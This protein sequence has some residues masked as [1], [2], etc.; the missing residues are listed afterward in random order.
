MNNFRE[1]RR[2]SWWSILST[3]LFVAFAALAS[4][5]IG[6]AVASADP[7][8]SPLSIH[9][10]NPPE[11]R[12]SLSIDQENYECKGQV[13]PG[14]VSILECGEQRQA[15]AEFK[16]FN[17]NK[18]GVLAVYQ[19]GKQSGAL[20]LMERQGQT[21]AVLGF[22]PVTIPGFGSLKVFETYIINPMKSDLSEDE[23][24]QTLPSFIRSLGANVNISTLRDKVANKEYKSFVVKEEAARSVNP[25]TNPSPVTEKRNSIEAETNS[26]IERELEIEAKP[27][28]DPVPTKKPKVSRKPVKKKTTTIR[29]QRG[30]YQ[31]EEVEVP[32]NDGDFF[33]SPRRVIKN[34]HGYNLKNL[35]LKEIEELERRGLIYRD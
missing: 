4:A 9:P 20:F 8:V 21:F 29:I 15:Q 6:R 19:S 22:S 24:F 33:G 31:Y 34:P 2:V 1:C 17:E 26:E 13:S 12:M 25:K 7:V 16:P 27:K 10:G 5:L 23:I 3:G 18:N 11:G 35:S 32:R 28:K 14:E 30:P